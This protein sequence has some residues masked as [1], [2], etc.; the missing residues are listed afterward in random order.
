VYACLKDQPDATSAD[1]FLQTLNMHEQ[2]SVDAVL[3]SL[4]GDGLALNSADARDGCAVGAARA[5]ISGL[6]SNGF[7]TFKSARDSP[8]VVLAPTSSDFDCVN[9]VD[10]RAK[11]W[12]ISRFCYLH[13]HDGEIVLRNPKALCFLTIKDS[14]VLQLLFEFNC[15]TA[16]SSLQVPPQIADQ[17]DS[18]FAMLVQAQAILPCN[19][20]G[21][22]LEDCEPTQR[23]WDFHDLLFHSSSR[24]GRSEKPIGGT[25]R[26]KGI[27]PPQ[28]AIKPNP[29][30]GDAIPLY[31]PNLHALFHRDMP[32]T[33]ALETRRSTRSHSLIPLTLEQLGE[34]LY[35][36]LRNRS[37]Y[38]NGYGEFTS[39]P[40]PSGGAS[41]ENEIYVT[42]SACVGIRRG[43]YY[44]SPQ[45]HTLCRVAEPCADM[46]AMLDE[47]WL[48][49][50]MMCR[51]QILLTIASRFNRFNWKYT[52]MS[53]AAQLK[54]VGVI[55]QTLY[56]VATA[57]NIGACGL[58]T[59]NADRFA[60]L[61]GLPYME[62]GSIGEFML[63]RPL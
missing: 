26:F 63:G 23:Q 48:A 61:T 1:R 46:E 11:T 58:G 5:I 36:S 33:A 29:W 45:D 55:Y 56:L 37:H 38:S 32:L 34:L 4:K 28:P 50:A 53:Y 12:K 24:L 35:R 49:T 57:M 6:A 13:Q 25:F 30:T 44:Y 47:A 59:G 41:Y 52:G 14:A 19:A 7:L 40:H 2:T 16:R 21:K 51:P 54:N 9:D 18:I 10:I 42:I 17:F 60:R 43:F 62:E 3:A 31:V 39:R 20:H 15:P 8:A 22:T 27:L